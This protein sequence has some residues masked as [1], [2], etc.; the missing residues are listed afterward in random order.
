[1]KLVLEKDIFSIMTVIIA[2]LSFIIIE[3]IRILLLGGFG[4]TMLFMGIH[5]I[6]KEKYILGYLLIGVSVFSFFVIFVHFV[7]V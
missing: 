5:T 4:L 2:V 7:L 6:S 3:N 1:M